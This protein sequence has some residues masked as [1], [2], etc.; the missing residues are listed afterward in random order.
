MHEHI[1]INIFYVIVGHIP[2]MLIYGDWF[3]TRSMGCVVGWVWLGV[4]VYKYNHD[5]N[6]LNGIIT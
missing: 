2:Q 3:Q 5:M 4:C 1:L 6:I